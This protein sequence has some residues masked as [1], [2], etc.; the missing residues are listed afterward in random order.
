MSERNKR[1]ARQRF[2]SLSI[3]LFVLPALVLA[4]IPAAAQC[5][6]DNPGGSKANI[7]RPADADV[8][9]ARFS[10]L[11]HVNEELPKWLCFTFGYRTRVEGYTAGN[12]QTGNSDSY[13]LTRFRLGMLLAPTT[14]FRVYA[15]VQD[16]DAFWKN[17]PLAPPYQSTWDLRRAYADIGDIERSHIAFRVGRQDLNFGY[18]RLLGTAY[19]RNA[20][21]GYDAAMAVLNWDW[22]RVNIFA[23]SQVVVTPNGL[24]HHQQGNDVHGI[25]GSLNKLAPHSTVEPYVFWHLQPGIKTEEG[26][27]AKLNEKTFGLRWAGTVSQFDYDAETT[28]QTGNIGADEIRA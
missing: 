10:P 6:V 27:F 11:S 21:R 15:E 22:F 26:A 8:P 28:G 1:G 17:P 13:L 16:A 14:W 7:N 9:A 20:S 2:C 19:W 23:A 5:I 25:Y 12:F 3:C 4:A 24:C 18:G